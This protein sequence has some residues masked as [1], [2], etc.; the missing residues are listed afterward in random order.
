VEF[1]L[2][3]IECC[4]AEHAESVT[5]GDVDGDG[6][7]DVLSASFDNI[8]AWYENADGKG[9]FD[10]PNVIT[11]QADFFRSLASADVD[12]DGDLDVLC[13]CGGN[14]IAWYQNTDGNGSFGPPKVITT[15]ADFFFSLAS[16]D[17]DGNGDLDVLSASFF[18]DNNIAW[19]ENADG[20]GGFGPQKVITTEARGATSVA[21][22]DL[23]GDGDLDVLSGS[24]FFSGTTE[25]EIAWYENT[26]G[27]GSFGRQ[28]L[29]STQADGTRSVA[30]ADVDGDLDVL[31]ASEFDNEIAWYENTDGKGSFG[32]QRLISTQARQAQSVAAGDVDGDGDLDV[33]SGS[34][35]DN[36]IAWYEN[37]DG[38][39]SF[40][41]QQGISTQADVARVVAADMDGDGDLDVLSASVIDDTIAWYENLSPLVGDS[42]RDDVFNS[43]DLILVF[44]SGEYEDGIAGNST[45]EEGDWNRDGEFDSADLVLAFQKGTYVSAAKFA[46]AIDWL[47][48]ETNDK[49]FRA[50][51]RH[52]TLSVTDGVLGSWQI[53]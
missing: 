30:S 15:Q 52:V 46:A 4:A 32:R 40:G 39:G 19:Y 45:F 1:A 7:L 25:N 5:T 11:T 13:V 20:K 51:L 37:T 26:D 3:N 18:G 9:G 10:P 28:R 42:N 29:I 21:A 44:Q 23:D 36:E 47:L 8:I 48:A 24:V 16:A 6:D 38:N 27:K 14:K 31:S 43:S 12:G 34:L 2:H 35:F 50:K 17:V 53:E 33:L 22:A 49:T 41:P